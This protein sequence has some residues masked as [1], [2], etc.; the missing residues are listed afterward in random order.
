MWWSP[1]EGLEGNTSICCS[2]RRCCKCL[3]CEHRIKTW[4]KCRFDTG[5][6][7]E[8]VG[9]DDKLN[10]YSQYICDGFCACFFFC[11]LH[12]IK[13]HW[14]YHNGNNKL[15]FIWPLRFLRVVSLVF[16]ILFCCCCTVFTLSQLD[17]TM[18]VKT[19][20]VWR[21]YIKNR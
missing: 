9:L 19:M 10:T 8:C 1:D 17:S 3:L 6:V 16:L 2:S 20:Q 12:K 18:I 4:V 14:D 5:N 11:W 7:C 13:Q 21:K 15:L